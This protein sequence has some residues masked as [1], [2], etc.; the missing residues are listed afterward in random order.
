MDITSDNRQSAPGELGMTRLLA[1]IEATKFLNATLDRHEVLRRL[2]VLAARGVDADRATL[3]LLDEPQG[4]LCSIVALGD[5]GSVLREIC[6]PLEEGLTG[7]V[8]RTGEVVSVADAYADPRFSPRIDEEIGY[9]THTLLTVPMRDP[10]GHITG[11][12]Q[13]LNKRQGLFSEEDERYL[14]ALSEHAALALENVRQHATLVTGYRRLSFLYRISN[15]VT[16]I[17][18]PGVSAPARMRL[19]DVLLTVMEEVTEVLEVESSAIL[20]WDRRRRRLVF[21]TIAGPGERE[22][23]EVSV[24]SGNSIAGWVVQKEQ[25]IIVN[26][27]QSDPRYY[28]GADERTGRVTRALIGAP[29]K[30][31]DKVIGALEVVNKRSGAPFDEAD[32][33]LVQAVASHVT[34]AIESAQHYERLLEGGEYQEK[35]AKAGF[36]DYM[37][38]LRG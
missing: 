1:L 16:G 18:A 22:L 35:R 27:V 6:L 32:L 8:A 28:R 13:A 11:V 38:L 9:R 15:L 20:L 36:L 19:R 3:Y 30:V 10:Q 25:A 37:G 31:H 2:M 12:V 21:G 29:L 17:G 14:L 4:E 7:Y 26:D 34:Q 24:P 23:R 33:Q 5:D